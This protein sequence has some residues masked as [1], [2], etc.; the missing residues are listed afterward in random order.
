MKKKLLAVAMSMALVA[1]IF[2]GCGS[3]GSSG[4]SSASSAKSSSG[5]SSDSSSES[6]SS[7][8]PAIPK[9][10]KKDISEVTVGITSYDQSNENC[11]KLFSTI[12][13][14]LEAKGAK[15][16]ISDSKL[17]PQEQ[18]NHFENFLA[19]G[20]DVIVGLFVDQVG[21][22]T[23][24]DKANE[25]GVPVFGITTPAAS[26]NLYY[27]GTDE[28]S[29]GAIEAEIVNEQLPDGGKIVYISNK[30]GAD[31][32]R[33]RGDGFR[34]TLAELNPNFE[35]LSEQE[36]IDV[37][38]AMKLTEDWITTYQNFDAVV[39][40]TDLG[41]LGAIQALK[42]ANKT[43]VTV[44]ID[45]TSDAIKAV[46]EGDLTATVGQDWIAM[47]N[48]CADEI[49]ALFNGEEVEINTAVPSF[50]VDADNVDQYM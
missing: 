23:M 44:S 7:S 29:M 45:G 2:A 16:I 11:I 38:T 39:A 18:Q 10:E 35:I 48:T 3:S 40:Q 41:I 26:A 21:I 46:S 8:N 32:T 4:S 34:E 15:V 47:G 31:S 43:A 30:L 33:L 37:E 5:S 36:G 49:E 27:I 17:D 19:Q 22:E 12:Q 42:A 28:Y 13:E 20:V 14:A 6:T 24:V 50:T 9:V 25:A 1:G